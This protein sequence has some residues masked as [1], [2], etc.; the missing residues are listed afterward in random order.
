MV[1]KPP[2]N[3]GVAGLIPGH[4]NKI[5]HATGQLSRCT[6]TSSC[7]ATTGEVH[8]GCNYRKVMHHNEDPVQ[9]KLNKRKTNL[10]SHVQESSQK[11]VCQGTAQSR[12]ILHVLDKD[13]NET[14]KNCQDKQIWASD[15]ILV[16]KQQWFFAYTV[17][18]IW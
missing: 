16:M 5:P 1:E 4:G 14:V 3:A 6:A 2:S 11:Y 18:C 17:S 15:S 10:V 12:W 8:A 7:G 13:K 9:A